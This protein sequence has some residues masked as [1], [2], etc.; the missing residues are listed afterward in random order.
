M[1]IYFENSLISSAG[2]NSGFPPPNFQKHYYILFYY[3]MLNKVHLSKLQKLQYGD[4]ITAAQLRLLAQSWCENIF[5]PNFAP[6]K[7]CLLRY[8]DITIQ[9]FLI[10]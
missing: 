8:M 3:K 4:S 7:I 5:A 6:Y 1:R 10:L 9:I 2:L